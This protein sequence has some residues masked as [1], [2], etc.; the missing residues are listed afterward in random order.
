YTSGTTGPSKACRLSTRYVEGQGALMARCLG[1]E[2]SDVLFCPYPLFHWDA[3][4]GTIVPALLQGAT[5]VI[6]PRFSASGFWRDVRRFG[7]TVFDF[8]GATLGFLY[9]QGPRDDDGDTTARLGWGVPMP[10]FKADFER[11]F[12]VTLVEGYGSTE[13]GVMVFQEPGKD[14]PAGSCG[15]ALPEFLVRV[16][17]HE[18]QPL[19]PGRVGEIVVR[20]ADPSNRLLMM[21][22]YF[23]M[24]D[25]T[26]EAFRDGWFHTGDLG[27]LD[28]HGHLFFEGRKK[29][30]IRRRG[31]NISAFEVEQAVE[32]HPAVFEAAAYGVPSE[33]TEE[34]VALAVAL[35]LGAELS[36]DALLAH[37]RERMAPH[38]VPLYVRFVDRLPK[39]PTEKVAK[40]ELKAWHR[41][42]R[43]WRRSDG[44]P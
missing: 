33:H 18:A 14:Y 1:I 28:T 13:G 25:A 11:R 44:P 8:M 5:A 20:P 30:A 24:P 17:D 40:T 12:D 22:G 39:T 35:K 4:I 27:R 36:E 7:V 32:E 6:A 23:R 16:V 21:S 10:T 37:C 42:R 38:M 2:A 26:A 9:K 29:D 41:G 15:E 3:T 19:P 34:E 31:E 43:P